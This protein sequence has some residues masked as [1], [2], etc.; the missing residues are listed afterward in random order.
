M[1]I[2][3]KMKDIFSNKSLFMRGGRELYQEF[4]QRI[5]VELLATTK[6]GP[7]SLVGQL[8]LSL[9]DLIRKNMQMEDQKASELRRQKAK[10]E[11]EASKKE[12]EPEKEEEVSG[13]SQ[14]LELEQAQRVEK[15][16]RLKQRMIQ[17]RQEMRELKKK[18]KAGEAAEADLKAK[19]EAFEA[20]QNAEHVEE[21]QSKRRESEAAASNAS[22]KGK[23]FMGSAM[24]SQKGSIYG[25]ED[26]NKEPIPEGYKNVVLPNLSTNLNED[27]DPVYKLG[28]NRPAEIHEKKHATRVVYKAGWQ[29]S[30]MEREARSEAYYAH[31]ADLQELERT[32]ERKKIPNM[33]EALYRFAGEFAGD[34]AA[35]ARLTDTMGVLSLVLASESANKTEGMEALESHP[36]LKNVRELLMAFSAVFIRFTQAL[37]ADGKQLAV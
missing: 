20:E 10:D 33:I 26:P 8:E 22:R 30:Y 23:S 35:S 1:V 3:I 24:G 16:Q 13:K 27:Q 32:R 9:L 21:A 7:K 29:F 18:V 31:L 34:S 36:L 2:A 12:A 4:D 15:A 6:M 17:H 11:E 14:S 5:F 25:E 19:E 28:E 37:K